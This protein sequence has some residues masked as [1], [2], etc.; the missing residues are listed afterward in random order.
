MPPTLELAPVLL[1]T[2]NKDPEDFRRWEQELSVI[3]LAALPED[4]ARRERAD[5]LIQGIGTIAVKAH[6]HTQGCEPKRFDNLLEAVQEARKGNETARKLITTNVHTDV[7][8]RTVK[9]GFVLSVPL[10]TDQDGQIMQNGQTNEQIQANTIRYLGGNAKMQPR[11]E[12]EVVNS[13]R[14]QAEKNNGSLEPHNFVVLSRCADDMTDEELDKA[15]FFVPTK[16]MAVQVTSM[17]KDGDLQM[18]S[19]F[20]AGVKSPDAPRH[21]ASMVAK[22]GRSIGVEL[23]GSAVDTLNTPLLIPKELMPNGVVDIVRMLDDAAGG[24][25]FGQDKPRQDYVQFREECQKRE[26]EM[27]PVVQTIV[28][29]LLARGNEIHTPTGATQLLDELSEKHTLYQA[30]QDTRIDPRVFGEAAVPHIEQARMFYVQGDLTRFYSAFE[31]ALE[32]ADSSSC[33]TGVSTENNVVGSVDEY[34]NSN[35]AAK[36]SNDDCE[37][38]SKKCPVCGAKN[39]KTKVTRTQISGSCGCKVKRK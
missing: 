27:E 26:T 39:V 18:E 20:V 4:E 6:E 31:S 7:F 14:L 24:T 10:E 29:E 33:P 38:I 21:D 8:E 13:F 17:N 11:F 37:F 16:S 34:G 9:A 22:F 35:K 15:G 32:V 23:S 30:I 1:H 5:R 36:E 19:A 12:A 28:S 25:F 3:D 2:D